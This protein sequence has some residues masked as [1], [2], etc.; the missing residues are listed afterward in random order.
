[1]CRRQG[2]AV[3]L[4]RC[5]HGGSTDGLILCTAKRKHVAGACEEETLLQ[6]GERA[7][8]DTV[9]TTCRGSA[10]GRRGQRYLG[11]HCVV[12]L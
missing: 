12:S 9:C 11:L 6:R 3:L 10:G 8:L 1:M 5:E 7:G 2:D 4:C